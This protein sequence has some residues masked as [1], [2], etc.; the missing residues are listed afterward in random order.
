MMSSS[1]YKPV[2]GRFFVEIQS[3]TEK[4]INEYYTNTGEIK[5]SSTSASS[6]RIFKRATILNTSNHTQYPVG[7]VWMMGES[8]GMKINFFGEKIIEI[9][10]KDLHARID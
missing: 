4:E 1:K 7:S 8:P 10:E 5:S 6:P 3:P 9:Q 2:E